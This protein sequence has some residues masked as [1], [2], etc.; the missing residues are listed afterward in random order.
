MTI[1]EKMSKRAKFEI[2]T[3]TQVSY[4]KLRVINLERSQNFYSNVIGFNLMRKTADDIVMLSSY[5][6]DDNNTNYPIHISKV[7]SHYKESVV[8]GD[9]SGTIRRRAGLFHLAILLPSRKHLANVFK[10]LTENSNEFHFEGAADHLVSESLYLRDPDSNGIE[11]YRDKDELEWKR[12]DRF[13]IEMST[14]PLNLDQLYS[15]AESG[16]ETWRMPVGTRIGHVHLCV[17]DLDR[18]TKF[19]GSTL[20][21]HQ[22]CTFPGANFFAADNYHHHVA[23]NTWLGDVGKVHSRAPGLDHFALKLDST[24]NFQKLLKRLKAAKTTYTYDRSKNNKIH[25][26]SIVLRDPDGIKIKIFN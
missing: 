24:K 26:G 2:S 1:G 7:P 17:S 12:T 11:I 8:K 19:Y 6:N 15:E 13:Q 10:H 18:S 25:D 22:T 5:G 23:V 14:L 20:G 4:V 16:N 21:F 3:N 9:Q